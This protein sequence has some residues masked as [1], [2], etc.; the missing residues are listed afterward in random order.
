MI[1]G[2]P[3]ENIKDVSRIITVIR[4]GKIVVEKGKLIYDFK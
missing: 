4:D 1:N 2:N 3:I